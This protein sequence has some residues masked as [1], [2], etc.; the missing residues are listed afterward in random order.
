MVGMAVGALLS[1]ILHLPETWAV[2]VG[3]LL[4]SIGLFWAG[5]SIKRT[6]MRRHLYWIPMEYWAVATIIMGLCQI[7]KMCGMG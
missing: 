2:F 5:I 1:G 4:S 3:A 6:G 7:P